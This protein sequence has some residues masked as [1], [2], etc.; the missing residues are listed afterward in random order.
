MRFDGEFHRQLAEDF[1][2]EAVDDHRNRVF[3][4]DAALIAVENLVLADFRGAGFVLDLR[5]RVVHLN[6]RKSVRAALIADQKRIALREVARVVG[7]LQNADQAAIRV[8]AATRRN[9]FRD[10]RAARVLADVNHLGAGVGLLQI[11][12]HRDRIKLADAAVALQQNAGIFPGDRAAGFDLRPG[13]LRVFAA[14][15]AAFRDEIV[16]AAFSFGVAGIPVLHRRILHRGV[17]HRDDFNDRRVQLIGIELRRGAA[18]QI[19]NRSAFFGDDQ[20]S[21]KL[22][23]VFRVDAEVS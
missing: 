21:F 7:V 17:V 22:S 10:D 16:D 1:F 6:V 20:R 8:V 19:G 9:A 4:R 3:G 13:N 12:G 5:A 14:T 11:V 18:F 23:G 2:A 15:G